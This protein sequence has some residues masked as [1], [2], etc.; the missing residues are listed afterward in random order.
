[1]VIYSCY[2][3]FRKRAV[4]TIE[5]SFKYTYWFNSVMYKFLIINWSCQNYLSIRS[6]LTTIKNRFKMA[7]KVNIEPDMATYQLDSVKYNYLA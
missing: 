7:Q 5:L 1:M 3:Y 2:T 6:N 4:N